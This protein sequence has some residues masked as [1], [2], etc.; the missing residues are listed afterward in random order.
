MAELA[1]NY[2][3]D[4]QHQDLPTPPPTNGPGPLHDVL[5]HLRP[6]VRPSDKSD[7]AKMVKLSEIHRAILD[8]PNGKSSGLDGIPH[9]LWKT[10]ME[11][12]DTQTAPHRPSFDILSTLTTVY[13]DIE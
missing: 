6:S 4:I 3:N 7:L 13:N 5:N 12:H 8:L 9:E 10:L 2:H 11:R 1:R